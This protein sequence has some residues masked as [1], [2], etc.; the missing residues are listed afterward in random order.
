VIPEGL[1]P[2][3][4]QFEGFHHVV[5]W[6]P[7]PT[8]VPYVCP[9]GYWTRGYGVLCAR[10]AGPIT[11]PE[12]CAELERLLPVYVAH[13]LRLS[14]RLAGQRLVAISDFIF[15][16]G[17]TRYASSTLRR[18]VDNGDWA[19]ARYEI[20]KWKFGGGRVLPGLV[21]RRAAEA[22]LL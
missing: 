4:K 8:A 1:T 20:Q 11:E 10:D 5:T 6:R 19:A 12:G 17:P 15:N 9:A 18:R 2:L 3:V 16:L 14:P 22:A 7:F 21:I 13:A